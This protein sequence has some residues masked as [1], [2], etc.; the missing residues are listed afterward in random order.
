LPQYSRFPDDDRQGLFSLRARLFK[1]N[2][3]GEQFDRWYLEVVSRIYE[4]PWAVRLW[5]HPRLDSQP[6]VIERQDITVIN[7]LMGRMR[8][9]LQLN[10]LLA[11]PRFLL[12]TATP[13]DDE[14]A[15]R[16]TQVRQRPEFGYDAVS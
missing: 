4:F 7:P 2:F 13:V 3:A 12:S 11:N 15:M 10:R 9:T 16:L 5:D 6:L 14:T 1:V 8:L